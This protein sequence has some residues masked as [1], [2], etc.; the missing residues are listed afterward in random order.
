M[1]SVDT[2]MPWLVKLKKNVENA[3]ELSIYKKESEDEPEYWIAAAEK[4]FPANSMT[5]SVAKMGNPVQ[6]YSNLLHRKCRAEYATPNI[7]SI[8]SSTSKTL[9]IT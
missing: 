1:I 2:S 3:W 7:V 5:F 4:D 9:C 8:S 6:V